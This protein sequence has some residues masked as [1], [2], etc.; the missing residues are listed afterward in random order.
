MDSQLLHRK[1]AVP[2][3]TPPEPAL[4]AVGP[5]TPRPLVDAHLMAHHSVPATDDGWRNLV[6]VCAGAPSWEDALLTLLMRVQGKVGAHRVS[7]GWGRGGVCPLVAWTDVAPLD[8]GV[9]VVELEAVCGEVLARG[10][11]DAGTVFA[12]GSAHHTLFRTQGLVALMSAPLCDAKGRAEGVLV[13]ERVPQTGI[14]EQ[15]LAAQPAAGEVEHGFSPEEVVWLQQAMAWVGPMLVLRH[16]LE[17]PWYLRGWGGM[18]R[19]G[20]R[21]SDPRE[22]WLRG[23]VLASFG[24]AA[25]L[26]GWPT[27]YT[28]SASAELVAHSQRAM[29]APTES[30]VEQA[31]F[32]VGDVVRSGQ[33]LTRLR[34]VGAGTGAG[35]AV[36]LAAPYDGVLIGSSSVNQAG[37]LVHAGEVLWVIAPSLDWRV[38]LKVSEQDVALIQPGQRATLRLA[39]QSGRTVK[40][41]LGKVVPVMRDDERQP[42]FEVPAEVIGGTVAGLRP[43]LQGF[44]DIQMPPKAM[45]QRAWDAMRRWWWDGTWG[46]W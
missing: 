11:G 42:G 9:G 5:V 44:A 28:V 24:T 23:G 29:V 7:V 46:L 32:R 13:C 25:F 14:H 45:L 41:T 1:P 26:F 40:V 34:G 21:L 2:T 31:Q 30:V 22:K 8:E 19:L 43:G 33:V 12:E 3:P 17:L 35:Q 27:S 10:Q 20:Q 4:G 36:A 16:R 15:D 6:Q 39:G 38:V 37:H 18:S